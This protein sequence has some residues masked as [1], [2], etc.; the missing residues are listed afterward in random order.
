MTLVS[1]IHDKSSY[2]KELN[3]ELSKEAKVNKELQDII[4]QHKEL[5]KAFDSKKGEI[6][7]LEKNSKKEFD[8]LRKLHRVTFRAAAASLAGKKKE[9]VAKDEAKY[10]MAFENEQRS[11]RELEELQAQQA[12]IHQK[13]LDLNKQKAHFVEVKKRLG[14][15]LD[16]IFLNRDPAFPLEPQL[17]AEL[18]NYLEQKNLAERDKNR[19]KDS[20]LALSTALKDARRIIRLLDT[21][22]N[23]V[24]FE[25]FGGPVIDQEQISLLEAAKRRICDI[26]RM[27]NLVRTILP[28]IP[29]PNTLDVVT[30]N[31]LFELSF[32]VESIDPNWNAKTAQCFR[33]IA[34]VLRP[35]ENALKWVKNF[36]EYTTNALERLTNTLSVT[37]QALETERKRIIEDVFAGHTGTQESSENDFLFAD[38]NPEELPPPVYEGPPSQQRSLNLAISH[39]LNLP[40]LPLS[41]QPPQYTNTNTAPLLLNTF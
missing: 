39:G 31:P 22:I 12:V 29:R 9:I 13:Q 27:L 16:Q 35:I 34:G 10:Q 6:A 4:H 21:I 32:T 18:S 24:P 1:C 3:D 41:R 2:Y 5:K 26:Q 20:E 17:H 40:V 37:T 25:I 33:Q 7:L 30:N 38:A 15:L 36:R 8:D 19:L 28:E 23:Y 14:A 11:K